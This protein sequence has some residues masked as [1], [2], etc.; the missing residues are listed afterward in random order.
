MTSLRALAVL[1]Y[2]ALSLNAALGQANDGE[3]FG[4][5][6]QSPLVRIHGLP[7]LG[8]SRV[9]W[10]GESEIALGVEVANYW[11][12]D[13]DEDELLVLDGESVRTSASWRRGVGERVEIGLEVPWLSTGGGMLDSFIEDFHHTFNLPN[14]AR[15]RVS[16]SRLLFGYQ[17]DGQTLLL[18]DEAASGIGD[19]RLSGGMQLWRTEDD[20]SALALRVSVELPTGDADSLAGSGSTDVAVWLS[21]SRRWNSITGPWRLFGGGGVLKMSAGDVL[22]QQRRNWVGFATLGVVWLPQSFVEL[23]AQFD[24]NSHFYRHTDLDPMNT[25]GGQ[26]VVGASLVFSKRTLLELALIEDVLV[27]TAPDVVFR[28]ALR[29]RF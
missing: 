9:L 21:G 13:H 22:D 5:S 1:F 15:E 18:V 17:R 27:E 14:G 26:V 7:A 29:R 12:L 23:K 20:A 10:H 25:Q 3:P 2:L 4:V 16:A 24:V 11:V 19:V 8:D 6:N 28:M